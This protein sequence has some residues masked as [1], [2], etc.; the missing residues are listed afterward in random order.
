MATSPRGIIFANL[1]DNRIPELTR[2]RTMASLP[3]CCRYRLIDF[4]LSNMVNAG[5]TDVGIITSQN[6]GSLVDHVGA[7]KDWD[8]ARRAGGLQIITPYMNA[9]APGGTAPRRSRLEALK[10]ICHQIYEW[11][12]D[13]VVLT[14]CDVISNIDLR[15]IIAM[16]EHRH[17]DLTIVVKTMPLPPQERCDFLLFE[18]D[19]NGRVRD[20]LVHPAIEREGT[21][22]VGMNLYI[23][24]RRYLDG[25]IR[26]AFARNLASLSRDILRRRYGVDRYYLAHYDGYFEKMSSLPDYYAAT[27]E[28]LSKEE[29]RRS[30]F[31]VPKRPI[32]TKVRN[33]PPASLTSD[34]R[35]TSS[36]I[37]DGC[38]IEGTVERSVLFRGVHVG[39]GAVVRDSILFQD[40]FVGEE[41]ALHCV[42]TDKSV[43]IREKCS[44]SGHETM[45]FYIEKGK[46]V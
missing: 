3:F 11:N 7:G 44:L 13:T 9:F 41:V 30:L 35:V 5:I 10:S 38:V 45:P 18:E 40:T 33:S 23:F 16:H 42:I 19:E 39:R 4:P 26:D 31:S 2:M 36:L 28:L 21:F 29:Q 1:H 8:L 37:A 43:T 34:A 12:C 27:M 46:T 15:P 22:H 6:Y 24:S 25:V 32:F 20:V 17:A 14:D